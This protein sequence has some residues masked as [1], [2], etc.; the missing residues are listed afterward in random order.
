MGGYIQAGGGTYTASS[1]SQAEL[2]DRWEVDHVDSVFTRLIGSSFKPFIETISEV[3]SP[4]RSTGLHFYFKNGTREKFVN[5][6]YGAAF[7]PPAVT[8][9]SMRSKKNQT[10]VPDNPSPNPAATWRN[11]A[12]A[13]GIGTSFREPG[14]GL[15]L[16]VAFNKA[17]CDVHVDR[18]GF[19]IKDANG[20]V[21]WD[22]NGLLRHF[23]VDL[24]SDA[25]PWMLVS[26]GVLD[27]NRRPILEATL[28]PWTAVDL[29]SKENGGRFEIKIGIL[30]GGKF[31]E[32][33]LIEHF[34]R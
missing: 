27:N 18:N 12:A 13:K 21:Y 24:L 8:S 16:H 2:L 28:S 33:K 31:D 15:S 23:T 25:A 34:F 14:T 11:I 19:I 17:S 9:L 10:M 20:N 6:V 29:P 4:P 26:G 22:L 7:P 30:I 5:M 1:M 3:F 32:N